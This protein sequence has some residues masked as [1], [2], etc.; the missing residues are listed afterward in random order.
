MSASSMYFITTLIN[1][2]QYK[3]LEFNKKKYNSWITTDIKQQSQYL[4]DL[5]ALYKQTGCENVHIK[6]KNEKKSY[7]KSITDKKKAYNDNIIIGSRNRTKSAWAL[8]NRVKG[9]S[10]NTS[11]IEELNVNGIKVASPHKIAN[12]FANHFSNNNR[13]I[14]VNSQP[15]SI[16]LKGIHTKNLFFKPTTSHEVFDIIQ[17]LPPKSSTGLDEIPKMVVKKVASIICNPVADIINECFSTGL[18]PS[19]LKISKIIPVHK[20]GSSVALLSVFS[21]IIERIIYNRLLSFFIDNNIFVQPIRFLAKKVY[22]GGR[23]FPE[24]PGL[25]KVTPIYNKGDTV[26]VENYRGISTLSC[27][28]IIESA[29]HRRLVSHIE[30]YNLI[31][32]CQHDF[33]KARSTESIIT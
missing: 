25:S 13:P 18:I 30:K 26:S 23:Q 24:Q 14:G 28:S 11:K 31:T 12:E 3:T 29:V 33:R 16:K 19:K 1:I 22:K 21:K 15:D 4:R 8:V 5:Y 7:R 10:P 6:Y 17:N 9:K 2:F 20:K 32:P 27:F